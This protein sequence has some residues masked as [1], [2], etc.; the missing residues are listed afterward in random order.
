MKEGIVP[1][2]YGFHAIPSMRQLHLHVISQDL[3]SAAMKNKKH[4]N[5][6][7]TGFFVAA[8]VLIEHLQV[9]HLIL[10]S[11]THVERSVSVTVVGKY[12]S[13]S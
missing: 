9:S 10:A 4:W 5:S 1:F 12:P 11:A 2:R 13:R 3:D 7:S 6:F 8:D